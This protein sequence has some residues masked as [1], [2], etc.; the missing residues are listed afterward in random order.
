MRR[1]QEGV[2]GGETFWLMDSGEAGSKVR[3][4]TTNSSV[5]HNLLGLERCWN[6]EEGL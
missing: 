4:A 6:G 1:D 2:G 3:P 5:L